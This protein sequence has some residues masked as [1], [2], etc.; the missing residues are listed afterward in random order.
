MKIGLKIT[1]TGMLLR[2]LAVGATGLKPSF[3]YT[4]MCVVGFIF[5][6][7]GIIFAFAEFDSCLSVI[8]EI[9]QIAGT[10]ALYI[11]YDTALE[12]TNVV[13]GALFLYG[14]LQVIIHGNIVYAIYILW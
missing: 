3:L 6:V 8:G 4:I 13:F 12:V 14:L 7:G 10:V 11:S 5:C 2:M 9:V 1:I